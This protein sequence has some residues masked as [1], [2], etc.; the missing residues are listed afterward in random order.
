MRLR[1]KSEWHLKRYVRQYQGDHEIT[2]LIAT[3]SVS[4]LYLKRLWV[5]NLTQYI[6]DLSIKVER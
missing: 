5:K 2:I 4:F 3:A 6:L 1:N